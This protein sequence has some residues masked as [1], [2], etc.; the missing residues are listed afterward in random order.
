MLRCLPTST[1]EKHLRFTVK[2]H[3]I[4]PVPNHSK[5]FQR[6]SPHKTVCFGPS[7]VIC[8]VP[9]FSP[10]LCTEMGFIKLPI[11]LKWS[12]LHHLV[13][14]ETLCGV[15]A[16]YGY[17]RR[18]M[19]LLPNQRERCNTS[20]CICSCRDGPGALFWTMTNFVRKSNVHKGWVAWWG[21]NWLH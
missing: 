7:R 3:F 18:A 17:D 6:Y 12:I 5:S 19:F 2:V 14:I 11:I 16:V 8:F 4:G 10:L 20:S 9:D 1:P 15:W 13:F 21:R